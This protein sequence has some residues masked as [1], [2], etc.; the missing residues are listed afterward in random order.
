MGI[1]ISVMASVCLA[2]GVSCWGSALFRIG[3]KQL[4]Q[5]EKFLTDRK[6]KLS[7]KLWQAGMYAGNL[8]LAVVLA[9]V[10][11]AE[12]VTVFR[13]AGWCTV[14]WACAWT[15]W[16]AFLI[17]NKILLAGLLF[18][19]VLFAAE[20]V[21]QPENIRYAA[22]SAGAAAAGLLV[23]GSLCRIV[24]PGSVGFGDLKLF[25]VMG[26]YLG[27][28]DTWSAMF[29]TLLASFAASVF[30][31]VTK[32]ASKTSVMPFAPFLLFGTILA[33]CLHGG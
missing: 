7:W 1:K 17:P 22:V 29:Y 13:M 8:I 30:L 12:P 11:A 18:F 4:E 24:I 23:A 26:L 5:E 31:L 28:D 3:R 6:K 14:L 25:L 21:R 19:L 33:I 10:Y 2:L 9:A 16:E 15:D 20:A 32:R 27:M